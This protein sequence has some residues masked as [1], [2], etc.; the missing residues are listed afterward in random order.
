MSKVKVVACS[1]VGKVYGLLA[2]EAAVKAAKEH[3]NAELL[4]LAYIVTGDEE[5]KNEI[6]GQPMIAIDGCPKCCAG[7]S[8]SIEGGDLRQQFFS[9][10]MAKEFRGVDAGT[11]TKLTND[12][13]MMVDVLAKRMSE[14]IDEITEEVPQNV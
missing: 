12:G 11:A 13:W 1:G 4:C 7:K 14:K 5:I 3:E 8:A 2:R 9:V 10:D 6:A